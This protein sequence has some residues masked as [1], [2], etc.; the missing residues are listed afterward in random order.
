MFTGKSNQADSSW[1][2][3]VMTADA[4]AETEELPPY[5]PGTQTHNPIVKHL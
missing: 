5:D 2:C 3:Y 4:T 1:L